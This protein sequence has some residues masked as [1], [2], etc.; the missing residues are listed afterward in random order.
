MLT[1][2][3]DQLNINI[4]IGNPHQISSHPLEAAAT[5]TLRI[6]YLCLQYNQYQIQV[7]K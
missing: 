4:I 5:L 1:T 3:Y 7:K 6:P 2:N